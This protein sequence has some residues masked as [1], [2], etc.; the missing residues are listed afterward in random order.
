MISVREGTKGVVS[1]INAQGGQEIFQSMAAIW[2]GYQVI[3][4][5]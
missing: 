4:Y 3:Y 1:D 2:R 5:E